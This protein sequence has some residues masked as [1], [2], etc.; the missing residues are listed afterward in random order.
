ME[1]SESE[2]LGEEER[3]L[4]KAG[5]NLQPCCQPGSGIRNL[6]APFRRVV[7]ENM[8]QVYAL[9]GAVAGKSTLSGLLGKLD[10][11]ALDEQ[12][13]AHW[14]FITWQELVGPN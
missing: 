6:Q 14:R 4:H 5:S 13:R 11:Q 2:G 1:P 10:S 12:W 9:W 7:K 3:E 8:A